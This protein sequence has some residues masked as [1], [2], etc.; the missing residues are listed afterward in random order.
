[1]A[2]VRISRVRFKNGGADLRIIRSRAPDTT[3]RQ[4]IRGWASDVLSM[5]QSP[6]AFFAISFTLDDNFPGG[7]STETSYWSDRNELQYD[8]L[9]DLA[10][11]V[12]RREITNNAAERRIM[13]AM[14]YVPDDD[15]AA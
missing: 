6:D 8:M 3:C 2:N 5:P 14:G 11:N 4:Y 13:R 7:V 12:I 9:P 1:M 10:R 15:G